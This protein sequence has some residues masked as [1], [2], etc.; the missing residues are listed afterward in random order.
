M[1]NFYNEPPFARQLQR[2]VGEAG[3]IPEKV[4]QAY[5]LG[6]VEAFLTNGNGVAWN[7]EPVYLE[8]MHQF[9]PRQA[10][11][12]VVAFRSTVIASKLQFILCQK[13]YRELLEMMINQVSNPAV[14]E[15]IEDIRA[16]LNSNVPPERLRE[17]RRLAEKIDNLRKI[18]NV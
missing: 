12:A 18:L 15:L 7:A 17:D 3:R 6:V 9:D 14:K 8:L 4:T 13:K 10:L 1:N 2:L 5:V 11:I 16:T